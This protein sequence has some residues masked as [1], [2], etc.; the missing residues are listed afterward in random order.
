MKCGEHEVERGND[1]FDQADECNEYEI[2][3]ANQEP[4]NPQ[5]DEID[6]EKT[7]APEDTK[8]IANKEN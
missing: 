3:I 8:P 6:G 7:D 2:Q 1:R 5:H 4:W